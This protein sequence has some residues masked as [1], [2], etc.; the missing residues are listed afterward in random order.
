MAA[1]LSLLLV[2]SG[3][4][5]RPAG[6]LTVMTVGTADNGGTMYPVGSAIAQALEAADSSVKINLAASTGSYMN[7]DLLERGEIDLGL[8]S[9]DVAYEAVSGSGPYTEPRDDLRAVAALYASS[10]SWMAPASLDIRYVHELKGMRLGVGPQDSGTENASRLV[11]EVLDMAEGTLQRNCGLGS[12]VEEIYKGELDAVHGFAGTP[13]EGMV[14]MA[15]KTPSRLL[16]YT[17][18]ELDAILA[19]NA[20]YFRTTI[21]AGSYPGQLV[22][23]DT[24]GVKC[25]L[26]VRAGMPEEEVEKITRILWENAGELARYHPALGEMADGSFVCTD[27]PIPLHSGAEK[28]YREQGLL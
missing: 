10:S 8:V 17:D 22:N 2:L 28:F 7:V 1:A 16:L 15:E 26:C 12:G 14:A 18:G 25:L 19:K 13:I 21:P 6:S 3:C 23:V 5:A 4:G 27:L 9:G 20:S 11:L 24:F